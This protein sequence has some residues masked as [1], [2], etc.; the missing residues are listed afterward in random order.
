MAILIDP[1]VW[2]AHA[3]FWSHLVSD[4][5]YDELHD[6]AARLGVPRRGFDLDHYDV[7][8]SLHERAISLGARP[9]RAKQVVR[10]LQE[11]GL[12]VRQIERAAEVPARRRQYLSSEWAGLGS[13]FGIVQQSGSDWLSLGEDLI[14]RWNEPH[15]R[16]HDEQHLED[17][18]LALNH[19]GIR[20]ERIH[21]ETLLAAWFHDAIY[22]GRGSNDELDSARLA[23]SS[24]AKVSVSADL[25]ELVGGYIIATDPARVFEDPPPPLAHLLDADLA[26]FASSPSRYAEYTSAVRTEYAHVSDQDFAAGRQRIL[27]NYLQQ[28]SI[29]RSA[30]A[31]TLWETRAR[32]NL[33]QEVASLSHRGHRGHGDT[34]HS[35]IES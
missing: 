21:P 1:P 14:T 13:M 25:A 35:A 8:A 18:L 10:A 33:E 9:V 30:A 6:F 19:L 16:Y 4:K 34:P 29:Y 20:G 27:L 11:S 7:P 32:T 3:T 28:P 2:P 26:I 12:R 22:T 5:N 23:T 15:R 24:L 31:R 17:V